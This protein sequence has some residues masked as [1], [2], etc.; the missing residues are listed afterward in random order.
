M[1]NI[2]IRN[3]FLLILFFSVT[4][5][6]L[7]KNVIADDSIRI[8]LDEILF[9]E[10]G[11]DVPDK[12][13]RKYINHFKP[14]T[15]YI[16]VEL[17]IKNL[18]Y[19]KEDKEYK[20]TFIWNYLNGDEFGRSEAT[21]NVKSEW[22][23]AY[24]NRGWGFT[25]KGNW[26]L[27][28]YTAKILINDS[29]LAEKDFFIT[30]F[31]EDFISLPE[32]NKVIENLQNISSDIKYKILHQYKIVPQPYFN[33]FY[34]INF[35]EDGKDIAYSIA[36][37]EH[38]N[39]TSYSGSSTS[40]DMLLFKNNKQIIPNYFMIR[41]DFDKN[42]KNLTYFGLKL[43]TS[44]IKDAEGNG[45]YNGLQL[46]N[47]TYYI[48]LDISP[49]NKKHIY[50]LNTM[51]ILKSS[52]TW[53]NAY[54]FLMINNKK[55]QAEHLKTAKS[56]RITKSTQSIFSRTN[57]IVFIKNSDNSYNAL[58]TA[59]YKFDNQAHY[60]LFNEAKRI[61]P[62]FDG[63]ISI[64]YLSPDEKNVAYIVKDK[65]EWFVM[66]NDKKITKGY[67]EIKAS[68]AL[69]N[70]K[71]EIVFCKQGKNV[72]YQAK[73][74][75]DWYVMKGDEII[76]DGF[77]KIEL[78]TVN[79]AGDKIAYIAKSG[80]TWSAYINKR[81]ISEEFDRFGKEIKFSPDGNNIAYAAGTE[82]SMFVMINNCKVSSNFKI[83][84]QN[85]L[86][87]GK[88]PLAITNLTFNKTGD[89]LAYIVIFE[90][91]G[92][93][94]V[95]KMKHSY[96]MINDARISPKMYNASIHSNK[97]GELF[98]AGIDISDLILHHVKI[99]F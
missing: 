9:F 53:D 79:P 11:N 42:L 94:Y 71:N 47:N 19:K 40:R 98:Y 1:A 67:K 48:P 96:I 45:Y 62:Q 46:Y 38:Q 8:E 16:N 7:P 85:S 5:F 3:S 30:K 80:K 33:Y 41:A 22:S 74:K 92:E 36:N 35:S 14:E 17:N 88:Q 69:N 24:I 2:N 65:K 29:L 25:D 73:I 66:I 54:E 23:T 86:Y 99:E 44:D 31:D 56:I 27:G 59:K 63:Y 64:P 6:L 89:K 49:D 97:P 95:D 83:Q 87:M 52:F 93:E 82:D 32:D 91:S 68:K 18:N 51:P 90:Y 20:I 28:R 43:K 26:R 75:G 84:Y 78:I 72:I 37:Y 61:S 39:A 4:I 50:I 81:R 58:Y 15:Q 10:S 55:T 60:A 76:S 77:S 13:D 34:D 21:F 70:V 57:S 12:K